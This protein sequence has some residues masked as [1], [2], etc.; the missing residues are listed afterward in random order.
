MGGRAVEIQRSVDLRKMDIRAIVKMI[1]F[2]YRR[3]LSHNIRGD[4]FFALLQNAKRAD[5]PAI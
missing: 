4:A 3:Y 1:H 5:V 2:G